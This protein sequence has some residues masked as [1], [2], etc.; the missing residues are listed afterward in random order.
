MKIMKKHGTISIIQKKILTLKIESIE[1]EVSAL[2][3]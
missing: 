1:N 3:F 2:I